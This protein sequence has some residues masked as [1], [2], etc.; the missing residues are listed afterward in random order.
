MNVYLIGMVLSMIVYIIVGILVSRKVKS[1]DDYY[2]AGRRAPVVLI[3]G[4]LI[5]SYIG[6]GMFTGDAEMYYLGTFSPIFVSGVITLSGYF[7]GAVFFG[8]YLR[9]MNVV[10]IPEYFGKRFNSNAMKVL[11]SVVSIVTMTVYM[12]SVLQGIGTLMSGVTGLDYT[13][14]M[15]LAM[16]VFTFIAVVSGSSGV[17][18]TDTMMAALFTLMTVIGC[19]VIT[20]KAGGWYGAI[21]TLTKAPE[22]KDFFAW[23]G[24][25]G[26]I[27][28][29]PLEN[30]V[31]TVTIGMTWMGVTMVSPWQTSRYLMA[32]DEATVIRSAVPAAIGVFIVQFIVGISAAFVHILNPAVDPSNQVMIWA[33]MNV[34]PT[35]VGVLTLTGVLAAGISSA[36]TFLSQIGASVVNDL[37]G[38]NAKNP[39]RFG[40]IAMIIVSIIVIVFNITSPPSI[41]WIMVLGGSIIGSAWLPTALASVLSKRLTKTA[42]FWGMLLGFLSCFGIKIFTSTTGTSLPVYCEPCI[43]GIVV[44]IVVM[45]VVTAFTKVTPE[46]VQAR[47]SMFV[48]PESENTPEKKAAVYK[49]GKMAIATGVCICVITLL[50]W[51]VPYMR[52]L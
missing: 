13:L 18:I 45:L 38:K 34:M 46:E 30:L 25:S 8:R 39:I 44:N 50:L 14:C 15:V 22:T 19:F 11:A 48:M 32:K 29:S 49:A 40:Q 24:T 41:Y 4:S 52:A 33:A 9:R 27:F 47:E 12:I 17:L 28:G 16:I 23:M 21:E 20:H 5:A 51:A 2:V 42:A 35:I 31:W 43:V 10:T 7:L 26:L 37:A 6:T 1:I 3:A 36:T